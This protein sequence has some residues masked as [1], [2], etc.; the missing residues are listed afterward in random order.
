MGE[1]VGQDVP[2]PAEQEREEVAVPISYL[3]RRRTERERHPDGEN[4]VQGGIRP[5]EDRPGAHLRLEHPAPESRA[6]T[7][8]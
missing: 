3:A 2:C 5:A 6:P 4:G 8:N 1:R 7:E